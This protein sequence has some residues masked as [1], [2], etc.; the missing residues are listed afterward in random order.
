MNTNSVLILDMVWTED[1]IQR[2]SPQLF[3][4]ILHFKTQIN[5]KP[6]D[7]II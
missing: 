7:V 5:V 6:M 1:I 3:I 4:E 2:L